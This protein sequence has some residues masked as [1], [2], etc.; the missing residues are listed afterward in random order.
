[1]KPNPQIP[2]QRGN[3]WNCI[4][5]TLTLFPILGTGPSRERG[6][7]SSYSDDGGITTDSLPNPEQL[8]IVVPGT[9]TCFRAK[10]LT[11]ATVWC[12]FTIGGRGSS[13]VAL[14]L[15]SSFPR[16]C[17]PFLARPTWPNPHRRN[18]L[19]GTDASPA[20][21]HS[22]E[23][24]LL[25]WPDDKSSRDQVERAVAA[26]GAERLTAGAGI[27]KSSDLMSTRSC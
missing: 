7:R 23:T 14:T 1:M 17:V 2:R 3:R 12:T 15:R 27:R 16:R 6:L 11:E 9:I 18:S 25:E 20:E 8:P 5:L 22:I 13:R 24:R 4:T 10:S 26:A 21:S 19:C